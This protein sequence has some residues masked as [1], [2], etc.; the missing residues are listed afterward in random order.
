ME[1]LFAIV[2]QDQLP[3]R[4]VNNV[5]RRIPRL[6]IMNIISQQIFFIALEEFRRQVLEIRPSRELLEHQVDIAHD[7]QPAPE[8]LRVRRKRNS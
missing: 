4:S 5:V 2:C 8:F 1:G 7:V 6:Q 3:G